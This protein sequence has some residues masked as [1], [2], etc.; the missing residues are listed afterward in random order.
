[1]SDHAPNA[2]LRTSRDTAHA[3]ADPVCR[4]ALLLTQTPA[5]AIEWVSERGLLDAQG[6]RRIADDGTVAGMVFDTFV[7]SD[8]GTWRSA[9]ADQPHDEAGVQSSGTDGPRSR[10]PSAEL[11]GLVAD[12]GRWTRP[13]RVEVLAVD[14]AAPR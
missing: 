7:A 5:G 11:Q 14:P 4:Q 6:P 8:E 3:H 1:M 10:G 12:R 9:A 13:A 2:G